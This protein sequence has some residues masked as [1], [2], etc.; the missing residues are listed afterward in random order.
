MRKRKFGKSGPELTLVGLG[1][2]AIGGPWQWGWGPQDDNDSIAAIQAALDAGINWIDTAPVYGFGHAEEIVAKAVKGLRQKIFIA[3]KCGLVWDENK[4]IS[5]NLRAESIRREV[6]VSLRRLDT[7]YIDLYQHHWMDD[8]TSVSESWGELIKLQEEGKIRYLGVSNY[9][10]PNLEKCKKIA[11]P[12]SLQPPYSLLDRGI[13]KQIL[14]W[15]IRNDV[16]VLAYSPLQNGLLTGRFDLAKLATDDWRRKSPKFKEP[17]Y[18][19]N[20]AKVNK[21]S[22]I[23]HKLGLTTVQLA[24]AWI[25]NRAPNTFAL[26]GARNKAQAEANAAATDIILEKE[27]IAE[28]D[29]I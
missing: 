20:I 15:C 11:W 16:S 3:T 21:L 7:D 22:E 10:V 5:N 1:T 28:I 24:I 25:T 19:Q 17:Q 4:K 6:E 29:T 13:E 23:A 8:N 26:V 12:D 27:I 9:D 18:S 14:P 2:W